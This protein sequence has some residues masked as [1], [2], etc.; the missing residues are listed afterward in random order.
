MNLK[1]LSVALG[2]ALA[3]STTAK[4]DTYVYHDTTYNFTFSYPDSWRLNVPSGTD[5]VRI[6]PM[7][8]QDSAECT[9]SVVKDGRLT[10]YPEKYLQD[11]VPLTLDDTFWATEVLPNLENVFV[12]KYHSAAGLG[13]GFATAVQVTYGAGDVKSET[14]VG[15]IEDDLDSDSPTPITGDMVEDVEIIEED[16]AAHMVHD[17][18][19]MKTYRANML[20]SI[21][22]DHRYL[23]TCQSEIAAFE[24]W[25]PVFASIISSIRYDSRYAAFPTGFYRAF[26]NDKPL[27]KS[28]DR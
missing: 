27:L 12:H 21:Y 5:R 28:L 6:T 15:M 3:F 4:A 7:H 26:L 20:A 9:V 18:E 17:E 16:K 13:Q 2:L 11:A 8:G 22:G 14:M 10:L 1:V 24:K 23:F 19:A 25:K